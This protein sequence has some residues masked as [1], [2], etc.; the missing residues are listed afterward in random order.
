MFQ[1]IH[2]YSDNELI[3]HA[4]CT[5]WFWFKPKNRIIRVLPRVPVWWANILNGT[6]DVP[7]CYWP[8]L[9]LRLVKI[10]IKACIL[11]WN[12]PT[13]FAFA[14]NYFHRTKKKL[15]EFEC[16][17]L[18]D[19]HDLVTSSFYG[20]H[21]Q[22]QKTLRTKK[23][24][25]R[26]ILDIRIWRMSQQWTNIQ[27]QAV[28]YSTILQV[29]HSDHIWSWVSGR[30]GNPH[31]YKVQTLRVLLTNCHIYLW[32]CLR[33][34]NTKLLHS[35]FFL[36][37]S[38]YYWCFVPYTNETER[39]TI[40]FAKVLIPKQTFIKTHSV[41]VLLINVSI[42][43]EFSSKWNFATEAR[44]PLFQALLTFFS[45]YLKNNNTFSVCEFIPLVNSFQI[46]K[47]ELLVFAPNVCFQ[48]YQLFSIRLK[49]ML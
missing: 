8:I 4:M 33:T 19:Q 40:Y 44:K 22:N 42:N 6:F 48:S 31:I 7:L 30:S 47:L 28:K 1:N 16:Q 41:F 5:K 14:M 29:K 36:E 9:T 27:L 39:K 17:P 13:S 15:S 3:L 37:F 24:Q 21:Q 38:Q 26:L 32:W 10:S 18:L 49:W 11:Y 46:S 25:L 23:T 12:E 34:V 20:I 2:S 43:A 35:L 45:L